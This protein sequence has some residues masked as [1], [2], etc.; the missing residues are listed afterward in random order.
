V[1]QKRDYTETKR[2]GGGGDTLRSAA[3]RRQN[4]LWE[5]EIRLGK[6]RFRRRKE[7]SIGIQK[8]IGEKKRQVVSGGGKRPPIQLLGGT[9]KIFWDRISK[10]SKG[11]SKWGPKMGGKER[12]GRG[13]LHMLAEGKG[14]RVDSFAPFVN[15]RGGGMRHRL[16][17]GGPCQE[18]SRKKVEKRT[19]NSQGIRRTTG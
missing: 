6:G 15:P 7:S 19:E 14:G 9:K 10:R 18:R 12:R 8:R 1:S 13:V 17:S 11:E 16:Q 2:G 3:V 5:R 4:Q